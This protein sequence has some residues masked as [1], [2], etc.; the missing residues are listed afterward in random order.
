MSIS[1]LT[2]ADRMEPGDQIYL[3][4]ASQ[5]AYAYY[6]PREGIGFAPRPTSGAGAAPRSEFWGDYAP[7]LASGPGRVVGVRHASPEATIADIDRMR[8]TARFWMVFSH[9]DPDEAT[10][11]VRR[12]RGFARPLDVIHADGAFAVL[13]EGRR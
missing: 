12:A 11:M 8:G 5:Y 13:M 6:G 3:N 10:A 1:S 9:Y 4:Y 2:I 7:V